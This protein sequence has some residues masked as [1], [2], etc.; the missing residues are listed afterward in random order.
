MLVSPGAAQ[1]RAPPYNPYPDGILPP[2]LLPEVNRVRR[3]I[4]G[5]FGQYLQQWQALPPPT[6]TGNPPTLQGSGEDA[7]RILG[8]LLNY[9]QNMSPFKNVACA[10]CH[11]PYAGFSGPIPAVNLTM[12]AYPERITMGWQADSAAIHIFALF[13]A[14][15]L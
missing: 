2:N 6:V 13:P 11:L 12:V 5:I 15:L 8:G 4:R 7:I 9:D 1:R 3:E 14:T 10:S